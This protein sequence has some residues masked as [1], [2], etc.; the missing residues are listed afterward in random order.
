MNQKNRF[1]AAF[2]LGIISLCFMTSCS[3]KQ[4]TKTISILQ[5]SL[6]NSLENCR[7]GFLKGLKAAGLEN[8]KNLKIEYSNAEND[9]SNATMLANSFAS[10]QPDLI[11]TIS[12]PATKA[13]FDA[14]ANTN[15]PVVF[16][17]VSDPVKSGFVQSKEQPATNC[18][19][20]CDT[21]TVDKQLTLIHDLMPNAHTI[22]LLYT[23]TESNSLAQLELLRNEALNQGFDIE[24][25]GITNPSEIPRALDSLV[26]K[27][28]LINNFADNTIA[29]NLD[30]I[31]S[32]ANA[33]KIPVFGVDD[34][35]VKQGCIAA[36]SI[37]YELVGM[38]AGSIAARILKGENPKNIPVDTITE[39]TTV[40]NKAVLEKY[41]ISVPDTYEDNIDY[42]K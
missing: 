9:M 42:I 3:K 5:F 38:K 1:R 15:L 24:A 32:K 18:T 28:D 41:G 21:F 27:C 13:A 26:T 36:V 8:G 2:A 19:G 29:D 30:V 31:L 34:E 25:I 12:T 39:T 40:A 22:G 11:C 14:T 20:T 16:V 37:N 4:D 35:Q 17:A 10:Q 6:H 7:E 33:A 23:Q